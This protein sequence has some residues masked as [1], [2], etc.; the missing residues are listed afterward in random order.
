MEKV[1]IWIAIA[2]L[3]IVILLLAH[4]IDRIEKKLKINE[5]S[6]SNMSANI[7]PMYQEWKRKEAT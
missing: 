4:N 5:M 1:I 2:A 7:D 3:Y 6:V